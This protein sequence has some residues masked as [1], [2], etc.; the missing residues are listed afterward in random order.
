M[1]TC[2][3]NGR[4][5][6]IT[7]R[8]RRNFPETRSVA[9]ENGSTNLFRHVHDRDHAFGAFVAGEDNV[10]PNGPEAEIKRRFLEFDRT[11]GFIDSTGDGGAQIFRNRLRLREGPGAIDAEHLGGL[12]SGIHKTM[13]SGGTNSLDTAISIFNQWP[14]DWDAAFQL[15]A[16]GAFLVSSAH[17][18]GKIPFVEI[19]SQA[20]T[21]C[22]LKN[23]WPTE[24]A[25]VYRNGTRAENL[26]GDLLKF[27]T[28]RGE[29][30]V[31]F[32]AGTKPGGVK[33]VIP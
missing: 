3:R 29:D 2:A 24:T 18:H 26:F 12:A 8:R 22:V 23:P 21:D 7:S 10:D 32:P 14:D 27:P 9:D 30:V 17:I 16:Q 15:L 13:L 33:I 19:R 5:S 11:G 25:A 28:T 6:P 1:R 20:G 31:L 4:I